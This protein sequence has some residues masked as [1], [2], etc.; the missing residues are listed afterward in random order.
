MEDPKQQVLTP[1]EAEMEVIA[2]ERE[3]LKEELAQT[4]RLVELSNKAQEVR[5]GMKSDIATPEFFAELADM[6]A[7]GLIEEAVYNT[8]L[9][10][11]NFAIDLIMKATGGRGFIADDSLKQEI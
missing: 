8:L 5:L 3:R 2:R 6:F 10:Q 1:H 4:R 11:V 9:G 7:N